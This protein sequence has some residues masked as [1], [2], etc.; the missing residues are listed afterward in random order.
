MK[1]LYALEAEQKTIKS[2]IKE[3]KRKLHSLLYKEKKQLFIIMD[4]LI[5]LCIILNLGAVTLTNMLIIKKEPNHVL[6]EVNPIMSEVHGFNLHPD[7]AKLYTQII[8]QLLIWAGISIWYVFM[9]LNMYTP[10]MLYWF[11][12][13]VIGYFLIISFD[14]FNDFGFLL[15]KIIY[16]G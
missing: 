10:E 16:G 12:C 7:Y 1:K 2:F 4:V 5:I 6:Q 11:F 15:G 9:R 3:R 8:I 14:F 13:I